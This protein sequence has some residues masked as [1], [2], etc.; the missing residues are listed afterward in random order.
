MHFPHDKY[1]LWAVELI[2]QETLAPESQ[3]GNV[4]QEF[5]HLLR[6]R[7]RRHHHRR[8][9]LL[10]LLLLL[11]LLLLLHLRRLRPRLLNNQI[12]SRIRIRSETPTR[13]HMSSVANVDRVSI[14]SRLVIT[15]L[16]VSVPGVGHA[17]KV[18]KPN[19]H[20]ALEQRY[21]YSEQGV[22]TNMRQIVAG[23]FTRGDR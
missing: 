10:Q 2:E 4:V 6:R 5:R 19:Q 7:R 23:D 9:R 15:M 3:H 16:R 12:R 21:V 1:Q 17:T 14:W 13:P 20:R 18:W 8:R 22:S 11:L